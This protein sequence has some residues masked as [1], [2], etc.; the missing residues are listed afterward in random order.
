MS[1]KPLTR[2]L[3]LAPA[4]VLLAF[5]GTAGLA[6][7]ANIPQVLSATADFSV[8]YGQLTIVGENL[9]ST[10]NVKL[11]GTLLDVLS[12]SP[13]EIVASLQAVAGIQNLP[14]DYQLSV[15]QGNGASNA[16][17]VT[18]GAAGPEGPRGPKGD[19][20]PAGPPGPKGDKGDAGPQGPQGM[21]GAQGPT[22][23]PGPPGPPGTARAYA[24]VMP[25]P[26]GGVPSFD[27]ART[28]GFSSVHN[29]SLLPPSSTYCLAAAGIDSRDVVAVASVDLAGQQLINEQRWAYVDATSPDCAP[30]EF[31]VV[32]DSSKPASFFGFTIVVP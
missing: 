18:I 23:P 31:E 28:K 5:C 25:A 32:T 22:G 1:P 14:G 3:T 19:T 21:P 24:R 4:L 26:L 20:G 30:G 12:N 17:V 29:S 7:A 11:G 13:T 9:P 6:S 16:F 10:P 2:C 27:T 8:G 15:S